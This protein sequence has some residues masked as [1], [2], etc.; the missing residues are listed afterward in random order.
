MACWKIPPR[1]RSSC[2]LRAT[3]IGA[4]NRSWRRFA[5]G[6]RCRPR[7]SFRDCIW[8]KRCGFWV[9]AK[10]PKRWWLPVCAPQ[11]PQRHSLVLPMCPHVPNDAF[12]PAR[13]SVSSPAPNVRVGSVAVACSWSLATGEAG[14]RRGM[15]LPNK[16]GVA[17]GPGAGACSLQT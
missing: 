4:T 12:V 8:Q 7:H 17:C 13:W 5:N 2:H 3:P 1:F 11:A 6:P 15:A 16:H 14:D 9:V 10:R